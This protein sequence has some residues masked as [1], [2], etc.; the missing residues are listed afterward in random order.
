MSNPARSKLMQS[1]RDQWLTT[2]DGAVAMATNDVKLAYA[3]GFTDGRISMTLDG[4]VSPD[5]LIEC[6]KL[7]GKSLIAMFMIISNESSFS[8]TE[9]K[10]D[11]VD[12]L[13]KKLGTNYTINHLNN[14]I[15]ERKPLP[16][17]MAS[18]M[19]LS[20]MQYVFGDDIAEML[21]GIT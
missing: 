2:K 18:Y 15:A 3:H 19:R 10:Q 13:N 1:S 11:R 20:V 5:T 4:Y 8:I 16:K 7:A 6:Q 14:F 21:V 12:E 17:N 9:N